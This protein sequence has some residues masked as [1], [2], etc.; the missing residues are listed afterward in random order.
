[1]RLEDKGAVL[2]IHYR[3]APDAGDWL[4]DALTKAVQ[5]YADYKLQHGKM[6]FEAKP[7]AANKGTCLA[8]AV[9]RSPF[10]GRRVV[11]IGDDTTDEDAFAAAQT[12]GGLA[13]K[14]GSGTTIAD[15]RLGS[16]NDVHELLKGF[17]AE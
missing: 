10:S 2:A 4:T 5:P 1:V 15:Y 14:V 11:M 8:L 9:Q 3:A 16:V 12:A 13:I 7:R 17:L 6:V